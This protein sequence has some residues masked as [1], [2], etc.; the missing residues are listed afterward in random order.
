MGSLSLEIVKEREIVGGFAMGK[1]V[2]VLTEEL[3]HYF[4]QT[5]HKSREREPLHLALF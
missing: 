2:R 4:V 1:G 5:Y 3:A